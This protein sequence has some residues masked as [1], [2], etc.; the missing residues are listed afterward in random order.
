M[1][2]DGYRT[3]VVHEN[4][5]IEFDAVRV[6]E[7]RGE[8]KP[9]IML[10]KEGRELVVEIAVTHRC[11]KAKVEKF[12]SSETSAIEIDLSR[13]PYDAPIEVIR[14]SVIETAP[15]TWV[16]N[17]V[18]E[19][20]A[21]RVIEQWREEHGARQE[22]QR[23]ALREYR[24]REN[25]RAEARAREIAKELAAYSHQP[26]KKRFLSDSIALVARYGLEALTGIEFEGAAS[27]IVPPAAWQSHVLKNFILVS[28]RRYGLEFRA[29]WV[30]KKLGELECIGP[31][32]RG[33]IHERTTRAVNALGINFRAPYDVVWDYLEFLARNRIVRSYGRGRWYPT[34]DLARRPAVGIEYSGVIGVAP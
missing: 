9:D 25:A 19:K 2:K 32:C 14:E 28:S 8:V 33:Y 22:R 1:A 18:L 12:R 20:K 27:F 7:R 4:R 34:Y 16:H 26:V 13:L 21:E 10:I 3:K 30:P 17:P 29:A 23:A 11:D 31:A 15:R 24:Q 6:E 5:C